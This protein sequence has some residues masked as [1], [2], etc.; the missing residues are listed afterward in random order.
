VRIAWLAFAQRDL[1]SIFHYY[2]GVASREVASRVLQRII[3]S[4][5][6]LAENPYL[7]HPSTSA[8][9]VHELQVAKLPYLLPYRVLGE[10]VEILRVFHECQDRPSLWQAE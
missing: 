9:G 4:A 3:Q 10:R 5:S 2:E 6:A 8:E 7:G 1:A